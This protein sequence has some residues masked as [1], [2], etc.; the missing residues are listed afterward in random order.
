VSDPRTTPDG[1]RR[2]APPRAGIVA[3]VAA[4]LLTA[5]FV[6]LALASTRESALT[7]WDQ[8]VADAFVAW[9]SAV[10]SHV[11]WA[12]TLLGNAPVLA[13]LS[14][15]VVLLL[16]VWG[17]RGRA[18]LV[19]VGMLIG[20]GLSETAKAVI[21]RPRPPVEEALIAM[22][23]SASMPSGHTLT[24]FVFLGLLVYLVIGARRAAS[25]RRGTVPASV[26]AAVAIAVAGAIALVGVIGVSRVYLGVHW[27]SDVIGGWL[28]GGAWL[29]AYLGG[30]WVWMRRKLRD[31]RLF[32]CRPPLRVAVRVAAVAIA[33]VL[34][35]AVYLL[36]A[37]ADP[38]LAEM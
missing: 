11:F 34:F 14:C 18:V 16:V 3:A 23:S 24:T 20:W 29:T 31:V 25:G 12:L 10:R 6:A 36:T 19:A 30:M 35:V 32:E 9:R 37:N 7:A 1:R 22:P 28:L 26:T 5:V 21:A 4:A 2:P 13:V 33:V 38:L 8:Q 15:S 17:R 27:M